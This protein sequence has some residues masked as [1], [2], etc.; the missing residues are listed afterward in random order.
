MKSRNK[1]FFFIKFG[2]IKIFKKNKRIILNI[3]LFIKY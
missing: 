3:E 2:L 1:I